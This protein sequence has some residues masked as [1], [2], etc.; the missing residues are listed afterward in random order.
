MQ[1][2]NVV[3]YGSR[4]LKP[5][6]K[7]YPT[8]DL[9]LAIVVFA[10][11]S[12]RHY[13]YGERFEVFSDHKRLKYIFTQRDLYLRQRR[14]MEYLEDYDFDLQYH[15]GKANV[16][17]DALSRKSRG[18]LAYLP[19][20]EWKMLRH[21]DDFEVCCSETPDRATLFALNVQPTLLNRV[22]ETENR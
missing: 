14:W 11:K 13:L 3:A 22:L 12:W 6:E 2:G 9:E 17:A 4:Q 8:H 21:L 16:V 15:P 19:V 10:L 1:E 7:N 5:H 18:T 20:Q